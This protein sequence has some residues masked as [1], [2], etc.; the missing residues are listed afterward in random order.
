MVQNART[1]PPPIQWGLAAR[2]LDGGA[3]SGDLHLVK[4]FPGGALVALVDGVGHGEEA[5][6]VA[7]SAVDTL[8]A[9]PGQPILDHL[10]QCHKALSGTRGAVLGLAVIDYAASQ[11][12]WVAVG[13]VQ[14]ILWKNAEPNSRSHLVG[15]SG[16]LGHQLPALISPSSLPLQRGDVLILSSD[17][18]SGAYADTIVP[19]QAPQY[20]ADQIMEQYGTGR[21]D[22]LVLVVRYLGLSA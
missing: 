17:G 20:I 16:V 19:R 6:S 4:G 8:A 15:R 7:R 18:I 2:S 3:C 5:Q 10:F 22:A 13:N 12:T 11:L 21:D 14:G 1:T 9:A